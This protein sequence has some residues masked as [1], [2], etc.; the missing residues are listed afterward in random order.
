VESARA[1]YFPLDKQR[2][3]V[4]E[5]GL[6]IMVPLFIATG[7]TVRV[8]TATRKYV[9]RENDKTHVWEMPQHR[10]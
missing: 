8:D 5:T 2:K 9:G 10:I 7:E 6:E 4:R 3:M 1:F